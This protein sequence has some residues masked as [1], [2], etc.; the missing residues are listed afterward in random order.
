MEILSAGKDLEVR[1]NKHKRA[2]WR[3]SFKSHKL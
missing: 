2:L 1:N 3:K